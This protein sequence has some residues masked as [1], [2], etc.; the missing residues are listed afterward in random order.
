MT[1]SK[2]SILKGSF[3]IMKNMVITI[4]GPAGSGKSTVAKKLA[5]KIGAAFLDTGAM[6]RAATLAAIN[7][8]VDLENKN[9]LAGIVEKTDFYFSFDGKT[10]NIRIN[11]NDVSNEIRNSDVTEK[12]R[13]IACI[14]IEHKFNSSF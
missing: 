14:W 3:I 9:Q 10:M 11:G 1:L 4:D 5:E 2:S 6:Y 7:A 8:G 12:S 13:H